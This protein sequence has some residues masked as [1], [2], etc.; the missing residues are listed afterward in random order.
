MAQEEKWLAARRRVKSEVGNRH[1]YKEVKAIVYSLSLQR[2]QR[3]LL[4]G[5]TPWEMMES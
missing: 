2:P 1:S 3:P 4:R 5:E